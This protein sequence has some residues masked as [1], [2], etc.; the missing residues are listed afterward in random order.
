[1]PLGLPT[2][3]Q[4]LH[5][6]AHQSTPLQMPQSEMAKG[7]SKRSCSKSVLMPVIIPGLLAGLLALSGCSSLGIS[8]Q[9]GSAVQTAEAANK[10]DSGELAGTKPSELIDKTESDLN[11]DANTM[12]KIMAAELLLKRKQPQAAYN[13]LYPITKELNEPDLAARLFQVAMATYNLESI[14]QATELWRTISPE[15]S[16][17]WRASFILSL[18]KGDMQKALNE[19]DRYQQL[20]KE[21]LASDL[22]A[23]ATKVG[24][25]VPTQQA[26]AF[27]EE[28]TQ[29]YPNEWAAFY[30]L[31]MVSAMVN[32]PDVGIPALHQA[33]DLLDSDGKDSN[34]LIYNLLSRLYLLVEP[35]QK[36]IEALQPYLDKNPTDLLVQE[37]LARLEV[38]AKMLGAAEERYKYIVEQEPMATT[39]LFS[40]ALIQM[41]RDAFAEAEQNL[42]KVSKEKGYQDAALYY[43]GIL[44]QDKG[45][46][47]KARAY[48][49][50]VQ[51]ASYDLDAK[52]HLAE[53]M[54]EQGEQQQA[55]D[56]LDSIKVEQTADKVKLLRAQAILQTSNDDYAKAIELYNQVLKLDS[57]NLPV[58]KAQ[59]L[60]FYQ[61]EDFVS[62]ENNLLQAL[63]V[64]AN[65]SEALNALGYFYV[66][67][68]TK[69]DTAFVLLNRAVELE[70]NSYFILDSMG[71]YYY[72]VGEFDKAKDFL[73]RALKIS[74]DDEVLM[75]LIATY[76]AE[77]DQQAARNL[78]QKYRQDFS[79]NQDF[80][81]IINDLEQGRF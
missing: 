81:N 28:M 46:L 54:F 20:S 17:A 39:S 50:Q 33:S 41:E 14:E 22:I 58:L 1:M 2:F 47:E 51:S 40:L 49:E 24:A 78:W 80:Q 25:A 70:P 43:L 66:E 26:L 79:Q 64:N 18:R 16:V 75:H 9:G 37:R 38:K 55:F 12:F 52:L 68:N 21:G 69:L 31:G 61:T 29:R 44:N 13:T 62:Y 7:V 77:G 19:W 15:S 56:L 72:R 30:G 53:I 5:T 6:K 65:D 42:I 23:S 8:N 45:S 35:P 73:Q 71:W 27:F 10:K 57:Q 67:N 36:G 63:R 60:L 32:Q 4:L 48:F 59:S 34:T 11:L 74:K 3:Y 76:W